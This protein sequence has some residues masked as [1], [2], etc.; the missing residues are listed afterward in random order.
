MPQ[1]K[2]LKARKET[3]LRWKYFLLKNATNNPLTGTAQMN[4][5][6]SGVVCL[7]SEMTKTTTAN[8]QTKETA[9]AV[10]DTLLDRLNS[11]ESSLTKAALSS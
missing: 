7:K 4:D 6:Q 1:T 3:N 5:C 11:E 9:R 2:K 10:I 8:T